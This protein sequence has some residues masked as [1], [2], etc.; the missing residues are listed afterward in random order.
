M[1][2]LLTFDL[3]VRKFI[4]RIFLI[5]KQLRK[6]QNYKIY[7]FFLISLISVTAISQ[8]SDWIQQ[9]PPPT[10]KTLQSVEIISPGIIIA[11]GDNGTIIKS[12]DGGVT[13]KKIYSGTSSRLYDVDFTD[14]NIGYIA[15]GSGIIL[16]STDGGETWTKLVSGTSNSLYS[17]KFI[18]ANTGW[19][20]GYNRMVLKTT[21]GGNSWEIQFSTSILTYLEDL[22]VISEQ[23]IVSV[24]WGSQG[25]FYKS[26]DGGSN[27]SGSNLGT[28]WAK[29]V[30]FENELKGWVT[31]VTASYISVTSDPFMGTT[32]TVNGKKATI[33]KTEDGGE[34]WNPYI[35][36]IG[37]WLY[38]I[39]LV[40]NNPY[41]VGDNGLILFTPDNGTTWIDNSIPEY[42]EIAFNSVKFES[43]TT[44]YIV[45]E[46][47][48]ILKTKDGGVTWNSL[49]SNGT[50]NHL[51]STF[52][53]NDTIGWV[54]GYNG[55]IVKTHNA[56]TTWSKVNSGTNSTL[57]SVFFS[58]LNNGW[59]VGSYGL[60]LNS[61]D[62][63]D[64][65]SQ[66]TSGV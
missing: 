40:N 49:G 36:N 17:V 57:N 11:V 61:A 42:S 18:N 50:T 29:A 58:D 59:C 15:G 31:G 32:I 66:Q 26:I 52:F 47:G 44:G 39:T 22:E 54:V 65:W 6:N 30:Q 25:N 12:V 28:A 55:T 35:F 43:N 1:C 46:N 5:F 63:G 37:L 8:N 21:N 14:V 9:S 62:G 24:G 38:D 56:G 23:K 3:I 19:I 20:S 4:Y 10:D 53:I 34:N 41:A 13:W 64:N 60:I 2:K 7:V 16:K 51:Y 33:W 45:G 48:T 27:W